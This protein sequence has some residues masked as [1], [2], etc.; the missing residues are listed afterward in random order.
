[1]DGSRPAAALPFTDDHRWMTRETIMETRLS[2]HLFILIALIGAGCDLAPEGG[3]GSA[4]TST[5]LASNLET[6][7]AELAVDNSLT[8]LTDVTITEVAGGVELVG[9]TGSSKGRRVLH[10]RVV[11]AR[12]SQGNLI[13]NSQSASMDNSGAARAGGTDG[14]TISKAMECTGCLCSPD[15]WC[16][17]DK[18]K[19]TSRRSSSTTY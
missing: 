9:Y 5:G 15:G 6:R 3:H 12:D 17:C 1:M 18:C 13:A 2:Y 4:E 14:G 16:A 11:E 10:P 19:T 7:H 8:R